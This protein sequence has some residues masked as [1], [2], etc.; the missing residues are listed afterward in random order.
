VK[1]DDA[2]PRATAVAVHHNAA[3]ELHAG[4]QARLETKNTNFGEW[5][6]HLGNPYLIGTVK[7][8]FAQI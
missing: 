2:T 1:H 5:V 7:N 6:A 8:D 4:S 3:E